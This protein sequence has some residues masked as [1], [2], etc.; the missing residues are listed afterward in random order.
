MHVYHNYYKKNFLLF[1]FTVYKNEWKLHKF[2]RQK[3]KK[4][5]FYKSKKAFQLADID[6][7]EILVSKN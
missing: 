3:N 6:L 2:W 7:N 1:F 4:S 5:D